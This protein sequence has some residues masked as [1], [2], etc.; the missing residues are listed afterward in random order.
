M[1]D[2]ASPEL[3]KRQQVLQTK[4]MRAML[5]RH[6]NIL[7]WSLASIALLLAMHRP[8]VADVPP[9]D[10]CPSATR[11]PIAVPH[12]RAALMANEEV[13]IVAL[14]SSSTESWMASDAA[15]SYPALLQADLSAAL[16][17]A[18]FAVINRGIGG[19]DAAE[20]VTRLDSDA[21]ALKPQAVIWQVGANGAMRHT[22]LRVFKQLVKAGIKRMQS[23]NL[24]IILMDNQRAPRILQ[25]PTHQ[26]IDQALADI[27]AETGVGLF[28]RSALMDEWEKSGV[29]YAAFVS[30]DSLHHNDRGYRC[31]AKTL[32][33]AIVAGIGALP[34]PAEELPIGM[35]AVVKGK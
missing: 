27:A 23:A 11:P 6:R 10:D 20:E 17:R 22:D 19:Q 12:I 18:H 7:Q 4:R 9:A 29:P 31:V 26:L 3:D 24:D 35:V 32:S 16:P 13:L 8:A 15:H 14:G 21:L 33:A 25:S 2:A 1:T 34:P 28:S 5:L 30:P